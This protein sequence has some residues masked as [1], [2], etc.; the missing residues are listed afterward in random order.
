[1]F[2]QNKNW[3]LN[4]LCIRMCEEFGN[5]D[6][7]V[8]FP[9]VW[10][11]QMV[12]LLLIFVATFRGFLSTVVLLLCFSGQDIADELRE[13]VVLT[14][15]QAV[16]VADSNRLADTYLR[17]ARFCHQLGIDTLCNPVWHLL[18]LINWWNQDS[19]YYLY[20]IHK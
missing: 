7:Y 5:N 12:F 14:L 11:V 10:E 8:F 19:F 16:G 17:L 3:F 15:Q 9:I 1:M 18:K 4:G 20:T 6:V 2:W 13:K